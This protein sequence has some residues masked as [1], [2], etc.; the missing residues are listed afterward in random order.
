MGITQHARA[1][2]TI[3]ML[4][5]LLLA[6]GNIGKPGA[7]RARAHSN[8]GRPHHGIHERPAAA[9]LDA[10]GAEFGF[11]PPREPG[12]DVVGAI[13]A[14]R[15]GRARVLPCDG[16]NPAAATPDAA[17][18]AEALRR[19]E[20]T[21]H[22]STKLNRSHLVHGREALILPCLGRSEIDLQAGGLRRR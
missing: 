18:T 20:L 8:A 14:M 11:A 12:H 15:T 4:M 22:V 19:S 21:A 16:G 3:Q 1:V 5:N 10:L 6:R 7:D 9:F 13:E 2:A 17:R